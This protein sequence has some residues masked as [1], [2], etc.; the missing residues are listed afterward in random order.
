MISK[1]LFYKKKVPFKNVVGIMRVD[2]IWNMRIHKAFLTSC[3]F[4]YIINNF[5]F[6]LFFV[7]VIIQLSKKGVHVP[8]RYCLHK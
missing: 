4:R 8:E 3:R 6:Y 2:D 5:I 1:W 7:F